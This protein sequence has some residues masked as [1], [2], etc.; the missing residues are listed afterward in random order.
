MAIETHDT[1]LTGAAIATLGDAFEALRALP[2]VV[3]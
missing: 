1:M 2:A 3:D